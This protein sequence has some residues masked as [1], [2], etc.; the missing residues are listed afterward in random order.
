M[1]ISKIKMLLAGTGIVVSE[2]IDNNKASE[3][4]VRTKFIQNDGFEWETVVPYH[5][6]SDAVAFSMKQ[7]SRLLVI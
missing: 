7:R 5:I 4:Y 3:S 2:L 1:E 6:I